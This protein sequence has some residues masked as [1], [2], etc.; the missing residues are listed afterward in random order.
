[1]SSFLDTYHSRAVRTADPTSI[2]WWSGNSGLF[3][4]VGSE[5][6]AAIARD[7]G[8]Q[9][10]FADIAA[11]SPHRPVSQA[12]THHVAENV[13]QVRQGFGG[14]EVDV[15]GLGPRHRRSA[16]DN[17]NRIAGSVRE[18]AIEANRSVLLEGSALADEHMHH[19]VIGRHASGFA[20]SGFVDFW[21]F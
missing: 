7:D 10:L 15:F 6:L 1:M 2:L 16:L 17:H 20:R 4:S 11:D 19:G 9:G 5:G 12:D 14:I 8:T 18:I 21:G 13:E 3:V